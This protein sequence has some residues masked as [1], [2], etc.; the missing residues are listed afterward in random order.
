MQGGDI[1]STRPNFHIPL[2]RKHHAK[3]FKDELDEEETDKLEELDSEE[4]ELEGSLLELDKEDKLEE[5]DSE[6]LELE[7]SLLELDKEDELE[8]APSV[9]VNDSVKPLGANDPVVKLYTLIK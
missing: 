4:L 6:E 3:E 2:K 9:V 8:E 1:Y 7:G 5:L